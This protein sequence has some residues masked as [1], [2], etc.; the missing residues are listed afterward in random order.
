MDISN[1]YGRRGDIANKQYAF[2]AKQYSW[3]KLCHVFPRKISPTDI[4]GAVE[5]SRQFLYFEFKTIGK[6]M[7]PGQRL[8]F[9]RKCEALK[10][11]FTLFVCAHDVLEDVDVS[12]DIRAMQIWYWDS[13]VSGLVKTSPMPC[14]DCVVAFW[15]EQW[16]LHAEEKPNDFIR[17]LRETVG[18]YPQSDTNPYTRHG[19]E[20]YKPPFSLGTQPMQT[21]RVL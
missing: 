16:A 15:I 18:I 2:K 8:F 21:W 9:D 1:F 5:V 3:S 13:S 17:G 12:K 20:L 11:R 10:T 19:G 4:E 6:Q 14:S 7:P